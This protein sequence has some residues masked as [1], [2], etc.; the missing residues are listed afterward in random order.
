[1]NSTKILFAICSQRFES[2][3]PRHRHLDRDGL[4]SF[5]QNHR[6]GAQALESL[7]RDMIG[8]SRVAHASRIA[9]AVASAWVRSVKLSAAPDGARPNR[10]FF[11]QIPANQSAGQGIARWVRSVK[12]DLPGLLPA[13]GV[14][15]SHLG[16]KSRRC[17][18]I[19]SSHGR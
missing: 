13:F 9:S 19:R 8:R 16:R 12:N 17:L 14:N 5:R 1:M 6:G 3:A 10:P 15:R 4:G 2:P 11:G 7:T 18:G